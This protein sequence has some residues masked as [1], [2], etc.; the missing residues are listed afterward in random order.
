MNTYLLY[1]GS[2]VLY[3]YNNLSIF[4]STFYII[5]TFYP[6]KQMECFCL[7]SVRQHVIL[8][9]IMNEK[10]S[11]IL[12]NTKIYLL[13]IITTV[14]LILAAVFIDN[15]N[16]RLFSGDA[17][18]Y[19]SGWTIS[20]D[21]DVSDITD[22]ND[23]YF[24]CK[25]YKTIISIKNTIPKGISKFSTISLPIYLS[26][27]DVYISN[28]LVY[29]Y[30]ADLYNKKQ[31]VGSGLHF[32]TLPTDCSGENINIVIRPS[33]DDAFSRLNNIQIIDTKDVYS[34]YIKQQT[35]RF[36]VSV[37]LFTFGL[38]LIVVGTCIT[39][40]FKNLSTII[41]IG[42]LSVSVGLWTLTSSF[43]NQVLQPNLLVNTFIEYFSL[44]LAPLCFLLYQKTFYSFINKPMRIYYIINTSILAL[45]NLIMPILHFANIYH[46]SE[47]LYIFFAICV[48]IIPFIILL[49]V[50]P[51]SMS[52]DTKQIF[53][54]GSII[55][56]LTSIV[57]M[58]RHFILTF[59]SVSNTYDLG[60]LL[61]YGTF[62][63]MVTLIVGY[64]IQIYKSVAV[65]FEK[66]TFEKL[67]YT[68]SLTKL[69]NRAKAD[70]D[71]VGYEKS[72][73]EYAIIS[74]DLNGLKQVNDSL[75]HDLGD[76]LLITFAEILTEV[77]GSFCQIYRFGGDEFMVLLNDA[78]FD[79][80]SYCITNMISLEEKK[81]NELPFKIDTSFGIARSSEIPDNDTFS[82]YKLADSRMY[83]MKL[84][85]SKFRH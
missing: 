70:K 84:A 76:K 35:G 38:I 12:S 47:G 23:Y 74:L 73:E 75:G 3:K 44:Y 65:E 56:L 5:N 55:I 1:N 4:T 17:L 67:A 48:P 51:S 25:A 78:D 68:D 82:V 37:F 15:L 53:T 57:D 46:I 16:Y 14:L 9:Q 21:H 81:S 41:F 69:G 40:Y 11:R 45:F 29:S 30:G 85:N 64:N 19:T 6:I 72:K 24:E 59:I 71:I 26:A 49:T 80:V 33:Q 27:I 10:P 62:F 18:N 31:L 39:I 34:L 13:F 20:V 43:T 50:R 52:K 61:P 32:I 54:A 79:K 28:K 60:S 63:F 36:F 7:K 77:F 58:L 22:L 2:T 8:R 83:E 42:L 66:R